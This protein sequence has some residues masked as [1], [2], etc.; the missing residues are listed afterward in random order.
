MC[1]LQRLVPHIPG[2]LWYEILGELQLLVRPILDC[3]PDCV[4]S[5]EGIY[6]FCF[7]MLWLKNSS[8][9]MLASTGCPKK[10]CWKMLGAKSYQKWELWGQVFSWTWL[11]GTWSRL[12]SLRNDQKIRF[13]S[14]FCIRWSLWAYSAVVVLDD[15]EVCSNFQGGDGG[16]AYYE[17]FVVDFWKEVQNCLSWCCKHISVANAQS[18]IDNRSTISKNNSPTPIH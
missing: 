9:I 14:V 2:S 4:L 10:S 8:C 17:T 1:Y 12:L 7:S 5:K 18:N 11:R 3:H 6:I 15:I 16:G 13:Y